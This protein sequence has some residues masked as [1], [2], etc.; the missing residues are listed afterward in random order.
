MSVYHVE[1]PLDRPRKM[2]YTINSMRALEKTFGT[3]LQGIFNENMGLNQIVHLIYIGLRFGGGLEENSKEDNPDFV[4]DLLQ[5][6][7]LDKNK[8]LKEL[9]DYALDAL[10]RANLIPKDTETDKD[11]STPDKAVTK[12]PLGVPQA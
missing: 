9:M 4:G 3:G 5:E 11:K 12:G 6:H 7:F 8:E 10:R 2:R 1:I